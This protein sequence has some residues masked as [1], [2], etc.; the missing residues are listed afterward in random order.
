M[1]VRTDGPYLRIGTLHLFMSSFVSILWH[2]RRRWDCVWLQYVSFPELAL[3]CWC[4]LLGF[5]VVVT[6][7]LG[8]NWR[9]TRN[10]LL[11]LITHAVLKL[12]TSLALLAESQAEELPFPQ[13]VPLRQIRTF[14]PEAI[15]A[16]WASSHS[17][18]LRLIHVARLSAAK[19]TF[20]FLE[21]CRLLR[22]VGTPIEAKLVG[23]VSPADLD[24]IMS[25]IARHDL[26]DIVR[27]L[28]VMRETEVLVA[29]RRSDV[30]VH[31]STIDSYPLIVLEAIGSGVY[32]ICK[33]LPGARSICERYCGAIV[34]LTAG[35][36]EV[37]EVLRGDPNEW[38]QATR[39]AS[40]AVRRDHDWQLCADLTSSI[41]RDAVAV[42]RT[43]FGR[44][45]A[46]RL[47]RREQN[48]AKRHV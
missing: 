21:V 23:Q 43:E 24:A 6:P 10:P 9:S 26:A 15:A 16:P 19:G 37:V 39:G 32:P 3:L 30:L 42:G 40:E 4:R 27:Y 33:D 12:S 31:L 18:P 47:I 34:G 41:L 28:G 45:M 22:A 48:Q 35:P 17:G 11:R 5:T 20:D 44:S 46:G 1:H 29:L 8:A 7:H 2:R 36:A 38:R 13:T 14:L 25:F